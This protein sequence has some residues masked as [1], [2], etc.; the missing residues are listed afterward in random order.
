MPPTGERWGYLALFSSRALMMSRAVAW[1][2]Q[3]KIGLAGLLLVPLMLVSGCTAHPSGQFT[4]TVS[5]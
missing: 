4:L 5:S 3:S 2:H 1:L